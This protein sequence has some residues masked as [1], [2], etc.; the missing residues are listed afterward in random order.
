MDI[1]S[2]EEVIVDQKEN[3]K[4]KGSFDPSRD[5]GVGPSFS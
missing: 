1:H 4:N 3:F 5:A 2:F